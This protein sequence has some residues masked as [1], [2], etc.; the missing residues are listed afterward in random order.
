MYKLTLRSV[1]TKVTIYVCNNN[2][3]ISKWIFYL[4]PRVKLPQ[5]GKLS[6]KLS[7]SHIYINR[8]RGKK[9]ICFANI[10]TKRALLFFPREIINMPSIELS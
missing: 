7:Y 3:C 9:R 10:N 2:Y 8:H 5:H 1:L 6:A 4:V